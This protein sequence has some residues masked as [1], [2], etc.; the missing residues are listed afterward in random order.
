MNRLREDRNPR[1][2][3]SAR[4]HRPARARSQRP[5]RDSGERPRP[6]PAAAPR[7]A[8]CSPAPDGF[9]SPHRRLHDEA[10]KVARRLEWHQAASTALTSTSSNGHDVGP[11]GG[12]LLDEPGD[13]PIARRAAKTPRD[14][15]HKGG[16]APT[17]HARSA[18]SAAVA[19]ERNQGRD[20]GRREASARRPTRDP[21]PSA[22]ST[23]SARHRG[24]RTSGATSEG[25]RGLSRAAYHRFCN[26]CSN[27][28]DQA[29]LPITL[30][31]LGLPGL[32]DARPPG[33]TCSVDGR[34][35]CAKSGGRHRVERALTGIDVDRETAGCP[36]ER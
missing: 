31:R 19:R 15:D 13:L 29:V 18:R 3:G 36:A 7:G 5:S 32:P 9:E 6:R 10:A 12:A 22:R 1:R 2:L 35:I 16:R 11:E 33:R 24:A 28:Q 26:Q 14:V 21:A 34:A 30:A 27:H 8:R 20:R 25:V 23:A 4:Q 17:A